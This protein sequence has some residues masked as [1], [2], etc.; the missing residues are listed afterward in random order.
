MQGA[1]LI[2]FPPTP[3]A[4][5]LNEISDTLVNLFQLENILNKPKLNGSLKSIPED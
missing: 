1:L 5:V 3:P 4:L 2:L